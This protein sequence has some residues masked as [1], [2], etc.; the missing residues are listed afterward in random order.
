MDMSVGGEVDSDRLLDVWMGNGRQ[1]LREQRKN[2][3]L[4]GRVGTQD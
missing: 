2:R 3:H 1:H 4:I